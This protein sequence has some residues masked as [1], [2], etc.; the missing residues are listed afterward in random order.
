MP[1]ILTEKMREQQYRLY[2]NNPTILT[3]SNVNLK[4]ISIR[5]SILIN[6]HDSSSFFPVLSNFAFQNFFWPY[7]FL[8][9]HNQRKL[10]LLKLKNINC[11]V[12]HFEF[13]TVVFFFILHRMHDG[14]RWNEML[15]QR[16]RPKK[17]CACVLCE[18]WSGIYGNFKQYNELNG[19]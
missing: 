1:G 7:K 8:L 15:S 10:D 5:S 6:F 11:S 17:M 16:A 18:Y 13:V 14:M 9:N 2:H 12:D 4:W 19:R 3:V